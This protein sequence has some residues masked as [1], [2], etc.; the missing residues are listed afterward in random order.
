MD[1]ERTKEIQKFL[2]EHLQLTPRRQLL[3]EYIKRNKVNSDKNSK[4]QECLHKSQPFNNID[5]QI[6]SNSRDFRE[7]YQVEC[8]SS[9][10]K[11]RLQ[12]EKQKQE[13]FL[14]IPCPHRKK[15]DCSSTRLKNLCKKPGEIESQ[16]EQLSY[17]IERIQFAPDNSPALS[18]QKYKC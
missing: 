7:N 14:Q 4:I 12:R 11:K 10:N 18:Y 8:I 17:V 5:F 1:A 15:M 16:Q 9:V 2:V 13:N 3:E 6:L